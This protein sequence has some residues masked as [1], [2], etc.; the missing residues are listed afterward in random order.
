MTSAISRGRRGAGRRPPAGAAA[1][2]CPDRGLPERRGRLQAGAGQ[3]GPDPPAVPRHAVP[4]G[5]QPALRPR[6]QRR[7]GPGAGHHL[8]AAAPA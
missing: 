2:L 8:A 4:L 3:A 7:P 6:H 1:L 5:V